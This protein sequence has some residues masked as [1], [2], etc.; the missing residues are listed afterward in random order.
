MCRISKVPFLISSANNIGFK[1]SPNF[2]C[3]NGEIGL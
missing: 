3:D 2:C 1:S